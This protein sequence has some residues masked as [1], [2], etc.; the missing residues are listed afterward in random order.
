MVAAEMVEG[1]VPGDLKEMAPSPLELVHGHF[2]L[3]PL[4][5]IEMLL[6]GIAEKLRHRWA[7]EA[8]QRK[9]LDRRQECNSLLFPARANKVV[10]VGLNGEVTTMSA[11]IARLQVARFKHCQG[12]AR[13]SES[14]RTITGPDP[15]RSPLP[16]KLDSKAV[17]GWHVWKTCVEARADLLTSH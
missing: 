15:S 11:G 8:I 3:W 6:P 9:P 16:L 4:A 12:S 17:C 7:L 13:V 14:P 5:Q 2:S 1:N 10:N